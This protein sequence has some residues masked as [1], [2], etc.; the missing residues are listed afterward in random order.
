MSHGLTADEMR[1]LLEARDRARRLVDE[2][3]RH[4]DELLRN[5][6]R[7]EPEKLAG[8]NAAMEKAVDSARN[9]LQSLDDA[10]RVATPPLN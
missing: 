2:L 3:E 8:G 1:M 10:L 5:P 9:T 7:L 4:R 6:P